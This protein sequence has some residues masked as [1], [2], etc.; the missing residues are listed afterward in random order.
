MNVLLLYKILIP[1]GEPKNNGVILASEESPDNRYKMDVCYGKDVEVAF[2]PNPVLICYR[3]YDNQKEK[4][5][6][7]VKRLADKQS[8][9]QK[10]E[11]FYPEWEADHVTISHWDAQNEKGT[12]RIYYEDLE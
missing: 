10:T 9:E 6:C 4:Y 1:F 7:E 8:V 2:G 3:L 11:E 12:I 5:V